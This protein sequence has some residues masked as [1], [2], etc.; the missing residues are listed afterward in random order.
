M[1]TSPLRVAILGSTGSLGQTVL[2]V[3]EPL[4]D[5]VKIVGLGAG[6]NKAL[7]SSQ[8]Q[9]FHPE[10]SSLMRGRLDA[11]VLSESSTQVVSARDLVTSPEVDM[12]VIANTGPASL[13]ATW[14]A[15]EAGK[16]VALGNI[17][18][19]YTAGPLLT[20]LAAETNASIFPLDDEPAGVWQT[21]WGEE[22][23]TIQQITVTSTWGT[24]NARRLR[25]HGPQASVRPSRRVGQKRGID[26]STLMAKATQVAAIHYLYGIPLEKIQVLYHPE[27]LVRALAEFRDGSVK[28][29]LSNPDMRVPIQLAL[30]YPERWANP[31]VNRVDLL[32]AGQLS[33]EPLDEDLFACF[34][35]A[36]DAVKQGKT[37]PAVVS[38]ANE[39]AVGLFLSQQIGFADIP[40]L[41]ER[42]FNAHRP[43]AAESLKAI[44]KADEWARSFVRGQVQY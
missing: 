22:I 44:L 33:F 14:D 26:A 6:S 3:I 21:L 39:A 30:A 11:G 23:D 17:D 8:I 12:A 24:L 20:Q 1:A 25:Q 38:A 15:V 42:A 4:Q 43:L 41:I 37:Y 16:R 36:I 29:V 10:L 13:R 9:R 35:L 5:R 32:K 40:S 2:K 18:V 27:S 19:L 34:R 31:D 7:L 28:A